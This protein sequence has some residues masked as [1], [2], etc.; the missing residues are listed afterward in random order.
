VALTT[1]GAKRISVG[2]QVD[3]PHTLTNTGNDTVALSSSNSDTLTF[4]SVLFYADVNGEGIPDN[5]VPITGS[6]QLARARCSSSWPP[7]SCRRR[8]CRENIFSTATSGVAGLPDRLRERLQVG[9]A[10]RDTATNRVNGLGRYEFKRESGV[11][12]DEA[13]R[14]AHQVSAHVDHQVNRGL[15]LTGQHAAKWVDETVQGRQ[16]HR[17]AHLLTGRATQELGARWDMSLAMRLLAD[18]H[19][20]GSRQFGLGAEAGYGLQDNLWISAGYNVTGFKDRDLA[21]D[22][23]TQRGFYVR[24]RFKFDETLLAEAGP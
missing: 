7:A 11:G 22:S 2:A 1:D 9:M 14:T 21:P 4:S 23:S 17:N 12:C 10:Y 6:G 24:L 16:A 20:G 15:A 19:P 13:A 18:G 3:Y 5:A 8:P